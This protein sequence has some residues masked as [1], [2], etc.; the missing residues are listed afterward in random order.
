ML[1]AAAARCGMAGAEGRRGRPPGACF[2]AVVATPGLGLGLGL[3]A[4]WGRGAATGSRLCLAVVLGF[5]QAAGAGFASV[6][7]RTAWLVSGC[8][9]ARALAV[10]GARLSDFAR[11]SGGGVLG[12]DVV[13]EL[14][15]VV[16]VV[17]VVESEGEE[18]VMGDDWGSRTVVGGA[19]CWVLW[20][21]R[22]RALVQASGVCPRFPWCPVCM[23]VLVLWVVS[24]VV[25][26]GALK[27]S[28]LRGQVRYPG[29]GASQLQDVWVCLLEAFE[30][31]EEALLDAGHCYYPMS[32]LILLE[33][34]RTSNSNA[35]T[36]TTPKTQSFWIHILLF[37]EQQ[38]HSATPFTKSHTC[39]TLHRSLPAYTQLKRILFSLKI[40]C[41]N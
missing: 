36:S 12:E 41:Q 16:V 33:P 6:C 22:T 5:G 26:G 2:C 27:L 17:D 18:T 35:F 7:R 28:R 10:A 31:A 23:P 15:E 14:D 39:T 20:A 25:P 19:E 24:C 32:T 9:A 30:G 11:G 37:L 21:L 3:A 1:G 29:R 8:E 4:G 34:G 13:L 38:D 40:P